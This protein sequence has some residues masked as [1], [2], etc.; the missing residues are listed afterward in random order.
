MEFYRE[1]VDATLKAL[2][3]T[4]KGLTSPSVK[5][6]QEKYGLNELKQKEKDPIWKLFLE[7]FKDPMVI[8]LVAAALVQL[9]LGEIIESLIIFVVLIVN[10]IISVVQTRKA[11]SSLDALREMSAPSAKVI[12]DGEKQTIHA[13]ELVPGDIVLLDA[14][15]F[16]PADGRLLE[17]GTLK[18]DEGMLTGE[19]ETVE[20][21]VAVIPE[22]VGL[23]DR[24]NMV[25]SGSLVAYG[26]GLF[27]VTGTGSQTEIG[28]IA[29]LLET[30]EAKQTPL[31]QKLES[32]SKKLGFAILALCIL[33]FAVEASRVFF[34]G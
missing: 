32:F 17:S 23:G 9:V 5:S 27:V 7:T 12:R 6:R 26:R 21:S 8:I 1:E 11:E 34:W 2:D 18:V 4:D 15:D 33:I 29:G 25:F 16:I 30:A 22:K 31:Q 24:V 13:N 20:K 28:K 19:S 10:S 14:G 3:A